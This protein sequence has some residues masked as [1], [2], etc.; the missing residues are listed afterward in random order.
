MRATRDCIVVPELPN[1]TYFICTP[2]YKSNF[3]KQSNWMT[4]VYQVP[5]DI[6]SVMHYPRFSFSKNGNETIVYKVMR[7]KMIFTSPYR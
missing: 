4:T 3:D 6:N 7:T 5:Y 2:E 1:L